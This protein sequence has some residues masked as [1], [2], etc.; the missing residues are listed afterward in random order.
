MNLRRCPSRDG[1]PV[2]RVLLGI[3]LSTLAL[4]SGSPARAAGAA[5]AGVPN[6]QDL[7]AFTAT[8]LKV[9]V[10]RQ[11]KVTAYQGVKTTVRFTNVSRSPVI[12]A[13]RDHSSAVTD[14]HGLPYRWSSKAYGIGVVSRDGADPQFEL[15]P[16]ESREAAFEG[17]LQYSMRRQ[18]AGD[19]FTHDITI[20]Q[21]A[22][23]DGRRVREVRDHAISF[24]GLTAT[25]GFAGGAPSPRGS[26][27]G[28][29]PM[30]RSGTSGGAAPGMASAA[31]RDG[32][33]GATATCQ[34]QGPLVAT[35]V[36][37]TVTD[38]GNV[39][40]YHGVR[41]TVRFRNASDRPLILGYRSGVVTDS[42]GLV[43]RRSSKAEG[44]GTVSADAADTQFRLAP[45]EAREA[46]FE[47][48]LQ[49][50]RRA[51]TP[52]DV[53]QHDLTIAEL[54]V[55][56]PRQV[57]TLHEYALSFTNLRASGGLVGRSGEASDPARAVGTL[58]EAFK[59]YKK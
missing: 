29:A 8:V 21:L 48:V 36:R 35:V 59:A 16:G 51:Q 57:R 44:I 46:A 1:R 26:D 58:V 55:V 6:C 12:L 37:V 33:D 30:A 7:G 45:G 31:P 20:V 34:A 56:G 54:E 25:S 2:R 19:V 32:C 15:A 10:T 22:S 9:N 42:N 53:F 14:N 43:Y 5:C 49:Y 38:S 28:P 23:A 24:S 39:T 4:A 18:V 11:D 3:F 13:Y 40:A 27:T 50:S 17:V 41:T 52:G 47:G